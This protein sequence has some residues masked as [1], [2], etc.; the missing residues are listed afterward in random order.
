MP[1]YSEVSNHWEKFIGFVSCHIQARVF[2]CLHCVFIGFLYTTREIVVGAEET[3]MFCTQI[4]TSDANHG[5]ASRAWY[6][7]E[8]G[9]ELKPKNCTSATT[10]V[11]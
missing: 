5:N 1:L 10:Q 4:L 2:Q 6:W 9:A 11:P 8:D 7:A 3:V